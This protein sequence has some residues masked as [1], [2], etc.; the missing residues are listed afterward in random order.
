M[1]FSGH[2]EDNG[3]QKQRAAPKK[4]ASA[5][6]IKGGRKEMYNKMTQNV[7]DMKG[8]TTSNSGGKEA[9]GIHIRQTPFCAGCR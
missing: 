2:S 5:Q 9:L 6:E 8:K 4:N 1:G 3:S 7:R